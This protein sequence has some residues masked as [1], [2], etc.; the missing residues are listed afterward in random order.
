MPYPTPAGDN[1]APCGWISRALRQLGWLTRSRGGPQ[2]DQADSITGLYN[3][4]GLSFRGNKM[5]AES[6]AT[7]RVL[8]LV[9]FNCTD[10]LEVRSIYGNRLTL[11]L[12]THIVRK[13]K[14][15]AGR[16]GFVARTGPAEFTVVMPGMRRERSLAAIH[17]VLGSPCR[18]EFDAGDS[19]IV[20]VPSFALDTSG[21]DIDS[22]E[23]LYHDQRQTL[24]ESE[25]HEQ[26]RQH[27]LQRERERHSRPMGIAAI[28]EPERAAA[29]R[30]RIQLSR[31]M[32][33]PL[34]IQ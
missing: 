32:P 16:H 4:T 29:K 2:G 18:I 12:V 10:L 11:K 24:E 6:H 26:R 7:G 22:I 30:A 27:Y 8:S 14:S 25:L 23:Q 3:R 19:E 33:A 17:R 13:L 15:L 28:G 1:P 21:P 20:L 9:V 5:L 34:V 31:T